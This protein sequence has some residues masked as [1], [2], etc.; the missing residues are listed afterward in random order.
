MAKA[1][2]P[3]L[4]GVRIAVAPSRTDYE[5]SGNFS[6]WYLLPSVR[7]RSYCASSRD[8]AGH[9]AHRRCNRGIE[10]RGDAAGCELGL[11]Q[12]VLADQLPGSDAVLRDPSLHQCEA[13][14]QVGAG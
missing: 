5:G 4:R 3:S 9:G 12:S 1:P 14:K 10:G 11:V 13:G 6:E 2:S 8:L 7:M